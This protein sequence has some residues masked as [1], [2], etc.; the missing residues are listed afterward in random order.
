M[1]FFVYGT[2]MSGSFYDGKVKDEVVWKSYMVYYQECIHLCNL[3][4]LVL[5][6]QSPTK[7][8]TK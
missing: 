1:K 6:L 4:T 2:S 3:I 8:E 7:L 5:Y